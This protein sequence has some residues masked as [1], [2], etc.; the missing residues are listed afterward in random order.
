MSVA[1]IE[2]FAFHADPAALRDLDERLR[3]TIWPDE[4]TA[5]PWRY[6]P[7]V[8][9][10]KRF[11]RH[12]LDRYDWRAQE[13]RLNAL[14][15]FVA[16][17]D[18]HRIH[19]IH[20]VGEG[21][22]PIPLVLTHGWPG[23][24][25]EM[26]EIIPL[27][28][29][30]AAHGG[31]AADAFTV[32]APS[33]PGYGFSSRPAERGTGVFAVADIWAKLMTRLNYPR[34]GVQGGDWGSWISLA[35]ALRHPDRVLGL[36][37]N[38]ISTRFRPAMSPDDPPLT[39]DE[40]AYLARVAA[41]MEAEG[42]YIAIQGTKPL[43]VS[44][45]LTDSPVGLAAWYVEKFR[46]WSDCRAEPDEALTMDGMITDIMLYWLTGTAHS[47]MRLYSESRE[48]PLH[49]AAGQRI[50]PPCGIVHLPKELPMPPRSWAERALNVVH[51]SSLPRGGHFAAWEVPELLA[52]DIRAFFRPMRTR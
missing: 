20:Q 37:L 45:A 52:E 44:Y 1:G 7:P 21:P 31:D 27:L 13:A 32:I 40:Q 50:T 24:F 35:A 30:P 25:V 49:L 47:A 15:Q 51:W 29:N 14:S 18:E 38:Y 3:R 4:V 17:I 9:Y 26:L 43:T 23:S 11:V 46:G 42:A 12:W 22:A 28:T 8:A 48:Q 6:G 39:S 36:H 34:F 16:S 5:E 41:W 33:I 2:H 10:M 19:F